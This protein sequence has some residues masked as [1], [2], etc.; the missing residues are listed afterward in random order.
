MI[1]GLPFIAIET[2]AENNWALT[3]AELEKTLAELEERGQIP[4][5]LSAF[6]TRFLLCES[7]FDLGRTV[8]TLGTTST[9]AVDRV[10]ELTKVAAKHPALYIHLDGA[11][12]GV[13]L[14]LPE[15]RQKAGL[16]AI[17]APGTP[18]A[19]SA[20]GPPIGIAGEVHSFCTN[21]HKQG[22]VYVSRA[23]LSWRMSLIKY[24]SQ[25]FRCFMLLGQGAHAAHRSA[26]HQSALL[27]SCLHRYQYVTS[28]AH[29]RRCSDETIPDTVVDYR[30]WQISLGR[31]FRSLKIYFVLRSYGVRGFQEHLRRTIALTEH[32]E[33]NLLED[34]RF[35][36]FTPRSWSLSVFRLAPASLQNDPTQLDELN[37]KY[38]A[39]LS[40]RNDIQVTQTIV[41][42]TFCIRVAVGGIWTRSQHI[43]QAVKVLTSVA[44]VLL[45]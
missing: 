14:A 26:R 42:G 25:S 1:L 30:N 21:L 3:G 2:T 37:R 27:A 41:G 19:P 39:A 8:A 20:G 16:A 36:L 35:V 4:F 9:G 45:N 43:D 22:L 23:L 24:L 33:H 40:T 12:A 7:L 15:E 34:K 6:S 18:F 5:C 10:G 44:D 17:N 28:E 32:F 31:K 38:H 11:W 13:F 29:F